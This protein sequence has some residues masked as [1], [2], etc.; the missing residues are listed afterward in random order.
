MA[1]KLTKALS[2]KIR[3]IFIKNPNSF[4][5]K[6]Y[7]IKFDVDAVAL[8]YQVD[9]W[10]EELKTADMLNT[11]SKSIKPN[12]PI[13]PISIE[14][15]KTDINNNTRSIASKAMDLHHELLD[16]ISKAV[17]SVK[18]IIIN[19]PD[20]VYQK[21]HGITD[22]YGRTTE[23]LKDILPA[24][25]LTAEYINPSSALHK[26][27]TS[28]GQTEGAEVNIEDFPVNPMDAARKYQDLIKEIEEDNGEL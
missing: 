19:N 8:E 1:K 23:F 5:I 28:S 22:S 20:G 4:N 26:I 21:T 7:A 27:I 16:T 25:S 2:S 9:N 18:T 15:P 6:A 11:K 24:L 12:T 17:A 14:N 3:Q 10:Y 13:Q